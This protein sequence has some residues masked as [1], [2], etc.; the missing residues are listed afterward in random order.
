MTWTNV[1]LEKLRV[2]VLITL[3]TDGMV[4]SVF[5]AKIVFIPGN[6][7]SHLLYFSR[8]AADLTQLGH[9][10]RVLAPSNARVPHF[11]ADV[12]SGGNFSY[13]M[14]PVD[15]DEPFFNSRHISQVLTGLALSQSAWQ[16]FSG[17]SELTK[18]IFTHHESDCV[19]LLDNVHLMQQIRDG[20]FQF[21]VMD[22]VVPHCYY[23]I[24]YSM[25]IHYA[26]L[27]IPALTWIYRVPR[28]PSFASNFGLGYTDRMTLDQRLMSF[29]ENLLVFRLWNGS[30]SY[31]AQF[32][33]HRPA[34]SSFQL[35]QQVGYSQTTCCS[36]CRTH[37]SFY[38]R[39]HVHV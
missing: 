8:L 30:T 20:G 2:V 22:P 6:V 23:A 31:V 36:T 26:T 21:A 13:T 7:N 9:V 28:L 1:S 24:P 10:T 15:G 12:E 25:G 34:I 27:S 37:F 39:H 11:V 32:A 5:G 17:M 35:L 14:Y 29:V 33:P 16:K 3:I 18:E 38:A 4:T 19:R